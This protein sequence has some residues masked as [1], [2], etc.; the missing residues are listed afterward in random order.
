MTRDKSHMEQVERWACFVRDNPKDKW[1]PAINDLIDSQYEI[2]QRFYK[3]L[4][5][6]E[7]GREVLER[8]KKERLKIK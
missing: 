4:E 2:A 5:K 8:L 3:N 7:K 6:T 1:K